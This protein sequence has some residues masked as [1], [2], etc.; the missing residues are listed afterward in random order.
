M[1]LKA[2]EGIDTYLRDRGE[3]RR[4]KREE[5]NLRARQH[6]EGCRSKKE[7]I[8]TGQRETL[9]VVK[10]TASAQ[11]KGRILNRQG[12]NTKILGESRK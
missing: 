4:S 9:D 2:K 11:V 1:Q 3:G 6:R 10:E 8:D 12:M 5:K 7:E